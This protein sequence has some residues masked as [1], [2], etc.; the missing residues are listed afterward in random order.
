MNLRSPR[1]LS[2]P[3]PI[4]RFVRGDGDLNISRIVGGLIVVLIGGTLIGSIVWQPTKRNIELLAGLIFLAIV[5]VADPFRALLFT[6]V[7]VPFPAYTSVGTTSMLLVFA[8]IGLIL[9]KSKQLRLRSPF[10]RKDLDFAIM[11][12]L[13]MVFLSFYNQPA[14]GMRDARVLLFGLISGIMLYY[15]IIYLVTDLKRFWIFATTMQVVAFVLALLGLFQYFYPDKQ[16]LPAFF[17]FSR[18][19]AEL[20]EIRRGEVRVQATFSGQELFAEYLAICSVFQFFMFRRARTL[21]ARVFWGVSQVAIL[22]ALFATATRGAL[23]ILVVGYTYL[24]IVGNRVVPRRQL[25]TV[26]FVACALFYL[27]MGLVEDLVTFMMDRMS[28]IGADDDSI[29]NRSIVLK[30]AIY[31]IGDSPFLGH[32]LGIPDGTFR[33]NVTRNIHNLYITL[34]YSIGLPGLIAFVWLVAGLFRLTWGGMRD[35]R[36]PHEYREINLITNTAIVMFVVDEIK[37]EFTRQVLT[38]HI[39]FIFFALAFV[40]WRLAY[41]S[42]RA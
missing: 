13:L 27:G 42:A 36:L 6:I 32:G 38:V 3:K 8:L 7:V 15:V 37:I 19:V 23:I 41:R 4:R 22:G 24:L 18:Q 16:V 31:A 25:L 10:I 17:S 26:M 33:G 20:E 2:L 1:S 35:M 9:M 21:R 5:L 30:Q 39:T 40:A 14:A 28:S 34:A 29:Q 11:G 12:F